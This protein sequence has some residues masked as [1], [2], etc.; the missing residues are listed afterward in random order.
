MSIW[1]FVKTFGDICLY[2]SV[3]SAFPKLFPYEFSFLWPTL[4]CAVSVAMADMLGNRGLLRLRFLCLVLQN[5]FLGA[6]CGK[7]GRKRKPNK[8]FDRIKT[9]RGFPLSVFAP[10]LPLLG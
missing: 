8:A 2:F 5:C 4:L 10:L 7:W 6:A 1:M 9:D 3:V